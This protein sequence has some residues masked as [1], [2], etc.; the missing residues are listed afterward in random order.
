ML[1]LA[2]AEREDLARSMPLRLLPLIDDALSRWGPIPRRWELAAN[3]DVAVLADPD[4][5][6]VTLDAVI[7]NA[8][9]FTC[10]GDAIELSVRRRGRE[11]AVTVTDSGRGIPDSQLASVFDRFEGAGSRA[12]TAHNFGL[13]LSI[14]RAIAEAHGGRA[15]AAR[16][17]RGG[18]AV[19]MWMPVL[20]VEAELALAATMTSSSVPDVT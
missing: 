20:D 4:R 16:G 11:A 1:L 18:A 17:S 6:M 12:D 15:S 10:E 7:D 9:R 3:D 5:L 14:V 13:G 2:T 8:V 19:T